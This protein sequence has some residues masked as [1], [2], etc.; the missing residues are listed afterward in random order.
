[1]SDKKM[2]LANF[3]DLGGVTN[4]EGRKVKQYRLLRS[5]EVYQISEESRDLLHQHQLT[6]IIDLRGTHEINTRPDDELPT[7]SYHWID[8]MKEAQ[9]TGSMEDLVDMA[10]VDA[11]DQHMMDIYT[12]LVT[13]KGAQEGYREYFEELLKTDSGSV[14][15]HCFAGKDRTGMAAA[16]TL[17]LLDVSKDAIYEDYLLT[18]QQRQEANKYFLDNAAAQGAQPEQL[19]GLKVALEVRKAYLDHAYQLIQQEFGGVTGY[20]KEV[21]QLSPADIRDLQHMYLD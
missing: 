3:R 2:K 7:V 1:M 21:L 15:F 18:N 16:L 8:I 14:L 13:T 5:G 4:R 17:E 19:A 12:Q 11:V 6:K 20:S 10:D 9:H